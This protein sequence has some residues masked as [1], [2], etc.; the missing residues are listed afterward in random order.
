MSEIFAEATV[1]LIPDTRGF[2]TKLQAQLKEV[3]TGIETGPRKP[4][5]R[6]APALTRNFVGD[7]RN[8]VNLAIDRVQ[9][10]VKPIQ[11]RAVLTDVSQAAIARE[12]Q[13]RVRQVPVRGGGITA[14]TTATET[15]TKAALGLA[16]A[17]TIL[18]SR[19][20]QQ[21][22]ILGAETAAQDASTKAANAGAAAVRN[23]T[24]FLEEQTPA[25]AALIRGQQALAKAQLLTAGTSQR[26]AAFRAAEAAAVEVLVTADQKLEA[27]TI[28]Q[29][30]A[31][32]AQVRSTKEGTA[33][34]G[35][36]SREAA[37]AAR[38]HSQLRRG[39]LATSLSFLGIRGATLAASASFLAGA[40]AI[41]IFAKALDN[42]TRFADQLNVFRATTGATASELEQVRD[43]ARALGADLT[44][45]GVTAADAAEAMTE[46]AKAGLDVQQSIA[47]ARGVLQLATA[48]A[49]DNA[50]AVELVAN[51]LNAFGLQGREATTVADAF[52]NAANAAQGSIVDIGIAFQQSAAAGRQVGLSFQDTTEFLTVLARAGLRGSDAGTSLRT[53]LIRLINPSKDAAAALGK[54]GI[55]VRDAQGNLRPDVF[56]QLSEALK[57][58]SPAQRDA[59][60]ALIGGQ[61][62]FRAISILGRQSIDDFIRLR[63]E[64]RQQGTAADLAA[65]RMQGLRGSLEGLSNLLSTVGIRIGRALTPTLQSS[66]DSLAGLTQQMSNSEQVARTLQGVVDT[67]AASFNL[68]AGSVR[69]A[70]TVAIPAVST[71]E[72]LVNAIGVTNIV[73]AIA[74]YKL[75]PPVILGVR[76]AAASLVE[77]L[78]TLNAVG[79]GLSARAAITALVSSLNLYAIGIAAAAGALL[80]LITRESAAE[81]AT[82][83]L[84]E[85]VNNLADAQTRLNDATRAERQA[86][87]GADRARLAL[88][89]AQAAAGQAR[90]DVQAAPRGT[91]ARINAELKLRVALD[92][93]AAA[94]QRIADAIQERADAELI[95]ANATRRTN[96]ARQDT[97]AALQNSLEQ[98]RAQAQIQAGD[99]PAQRERANAE[100]VRLFT[101]EL[102]KQIKKL[103]ESDDADKL[104][105]ANRL[106]R[107]RDIT[108][109]LGRVPTEKAIEI[110]V[111]APNIQAVSNRLL[112]EFGITAEKARKLFIAEF[113]GKFSS[114]FITA[115]AGVVKAIQIGFDQIFHD[116]G[117]SGGNELARG[118]A[119]GFTAPTSPFAPGAAAAAAAGN[120]ID[121]ARARLAGIERTGAQLETSGAALT[122]QLANARDAEAA[123]RKIVEDTLAQVRAGNISWKTYDQELAKLKSLVSARKALEDQIRGNVEEANRKQAERIKAQDQA[124]LD[125][126]ERR[127]NRPQDRIEDARATETLA[128][129][130]R[131]TVAFRNLVHKQINRIKDLVKDRATQ[132]DAIRALQ[133]IENDLNR[134]IK[135]LQEQ[136]R[137]QIADRLAERI[138]LNIEFAQTTK[139]VNLEI[140]ARLSEI[141]RLQKL[142]AHTKKGTIEYLRLRNAIAEQQAA[143]DDLRKQR[144]DANK[145]LIALQQQE[146]AFLQT[147]QGF[148]FNLL[149]NL[150][151]GGA[152]GGLVGNIGGPTSTTSGGGSGLLPREQVSGLTM[153]NPQFGR[154]SKAVSAAVATA[155]AGTTKGFS[156][157]QG[158]TTNTLLRKILAELHKLNRRSDHP[159]A[160]H[161]KK[162]GTAT[163]DYSGSGGGGGS[164]LNM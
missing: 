109:A 64:L 112:D 136:R 47:G 27:E 12:V 36:H 152:T 83:R 88:L 8:Q 98:A 135:S 162:Q 153:P 99:A 4:K 65:A 158:N 161:Q 84:G 103:R 61:D 21:I 140:R 78:I 156:A 119:E 26:A 130:I 55:E 116:I 24:L 107:L 146:F 41:G 68:L 126:L 22:P 60:I 134:D 108:T 139:N 154:G 127:R 20:A 90:A 72:K 16:D 115:I 89:D 14:Q 9:K 118:V 30:Q 56:I 28:R 92:D 145:S 13:G 29:A 123:Q 42:A 128:D 129:D 148:T 48:A 66:V 106:K 113:T 25:M 143:I 102:D 121:R 104:R 149:G 114:E 69:V 124:V 74:A 131:A 50:Q 38:S 57:N 5:I 37:R 71:L 23:Q 45:P 132:I 138:Q 52:A 11:V 93:V 86:A 54:L 7:L 6:V 2:A 51:A 39:A 63:R 18:N 46:L 144:E 122:T 164:A 155:G 62:A 101:G 157:G 1:T 82:R 100:A 17:E 137:K 53:A 67:L 32:R 91:Q 10:G 79:F 87:G 150:I 85:A 151:P 94:Q 80:F 59:T 160:N 125:R 31:L 76:I 96:E 58:V 105:Q 15:A 43:S 77:T 49:I 133:K 95:L 34:L 120:P 97:I 81:K 110:T 141:A 117:V 35:E 163:L 111:N 3:I 19:L 44:L 159:E 73:A 33:A 75:L 40:A 147:I 142:Q 70:G